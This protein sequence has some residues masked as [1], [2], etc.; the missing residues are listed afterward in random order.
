M[1][2]GKMSGREFKKKVLELVSS[3]NFEQDLVAL[4]KLP[5]RK[6][7]N[8][9]F[10]FL[11]HTDSKI[12]WATVTAFGAVVSNLADQ[13]ME[14]ARVIMRRLMWQLNDESGGIGWGCPE[15]IGEIVACHEGLAQ[16]YARVL[17]SYIRE[18]GN[19]LEHEPL[20]QGALWS[21]CRVSQVR[22]KLI[23]DA[24]PHLHPFL[25]ARDAT[26]RGLASWALGLLCARESLSQ[27]ERLVNDDSKI[28][29][30]RDRKIKITLVKDL[31]KE[32]LEKIGR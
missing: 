1:P 31:A 10:S 26:L 30:Y 5:A 17:I 11:L 25:E 28:E 18:D 24:V 14:S 27:I 4:C 19:I 8:P 22:P 29:I 20:Q 2:T 16:E 7:I 15:A 12:K 6:V 23:R 9:L 32:A 21:I 3:N 13:D